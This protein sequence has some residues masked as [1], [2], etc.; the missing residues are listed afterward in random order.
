MLFWF[1]LLRLCYEHQGFCTNLDL[2]VTQSLFRQSNEDKWNSLKMNIIMYFFTNEFQVVPSLRW[3][4]HNN[5]LFFQTRHA[6]WKV[7]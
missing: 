5:D 7:R 6:A 2:P 4:S 1:Q 3:Q